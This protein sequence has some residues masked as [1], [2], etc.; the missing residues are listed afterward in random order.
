MPPR[1]APSD[2][3]SRRPP[4]RHHH[5]PARVGDFG[6][7]LF[8]GALAMLF[9]ASLLLFVLL[10]IYR[11]AGVEGAGG[12]TLPW[13]LWIS[14][15]VMLL[16]SFTL[17]R[18][19]TAVRRERQATLRAMLWL[20]LGLA[21]VFLAI[22]TPSLWRLLSEYREAQSAYFDAQR[23]YAAAQAIART[24]EELLAMDAHRPGVSPA[25]MM[26]VLI[27]V[28]AAHVIGGII[29]LAIVAAKAGRG[30]Y[31]HEYHRPVKYLSQYWHFLDVVWLVMFGVLLIF[32]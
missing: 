5:V 7:A 17:Q 12:V 28:H 21:L 6:M 31:D 22:Q 32:T 4:E 30:R 29:P 24:P 10:G 20:T 14:T 18:A 27:L 3:S 13:P 26:A 15:G 16:S 19:L 1:S 23:E 9:A 2:P 8:L 11:P 25:G